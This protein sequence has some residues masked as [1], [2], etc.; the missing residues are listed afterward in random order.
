MQSRHT[1][2]AC[3][4][5]LCF[6]FAVT[7]V[8][9]EA[10]ARCAFVGGSSGVIYFGNVDPSTSPG[11]VL[12]TVTTQ[13]NFTCS[14]NRAFTVT[15]TPASG[16]TLTGPGSM[17]FTPG[18]IASGTG[19]GGGTPIA[20]LT[21]TSQILMS[22]YQNAPN[23]AYN[24]SSAVTLTINCPTCSMPNTITATIPATTG[25]TAN[26]AN[27]CGS[28]VSGSMS[29]NIDPSGSGTLTP[30]TTAN[31]TSPSVKCTMSSEHSVA[32]SS[33]HGNTLT[34]GNNGVT[35]PI[36]YTITSCPASV[37]GSGFSAAAS[38]PVGISIPQT[39]YQNAKAG[40]HSDTITVTV[41]Y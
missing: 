16:W 35:D 30:N 41:T 29:F 34:I 12:G 2:K 18:F 19:R 10:H 22:N 6:L 14:T 25:V 27:T 8:A 28:A 37:T 40:A 1:Y 20:L 23:G 21:N 13:I 24:N 9:S 33:A 36:A 32:C 4:I 31:G 11:P 15:A 39:S 3:F 7:C 5:S 26:I 17:A 38:I